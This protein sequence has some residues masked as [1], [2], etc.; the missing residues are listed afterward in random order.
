MQSH[1]PRR[2]AAA[3]WGPAKDQAQFFGAGTNDPRFGTLEISRPNSEVLRSHEGHFLRQMWKA[4]PLPTKLQATARHPVERTMKN[5]FRRTLL[6]LTL[7]F[8]APNAW[9]GSAILSASQNNS[10]FQN[11]V[12]NSAGGAAGI[13][14][15]TT[16]TGS[17]RR[18]LIAFDVAAHVPAG[19]TITSAELTL[20]LAAAGGGAGQ[21]ISLHRLNADWGEGTAGSSLPTVSGSGLGFAA[22]A[23]DATWNANFHS[24]T[25]W[26][27]PGATGDFTAAASAS[28]SIGAIVET[29][30]TWSSSPTMIGDV[31]SWLSDPAANFGWALVNANEVDNGTARAF[32]SRSATVNAG[33]DPLDLAFRPT[34]TITYEI[35]EP[36]AAVLLLLTGPLAIVL[37]RRRC[38]N[39]TEVARAA[40]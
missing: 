8:A 4:T 10:I 21:S 23:G 30:Y 35:P 13:F 15:G 1:A 37:R 9:A 25:L 34:L 12:N 40:A 6:I 28:T 22:G 14:A 33:G 27:S 5:F 16:A 32:Y 31:Q 7:T 18:G 11:A 36:T 2:V 17:P 38:A 26:S 24:S 19:A 39:R 29:P 3:T 20:Y